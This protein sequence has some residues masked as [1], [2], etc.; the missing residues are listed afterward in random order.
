MEAE[1]IRYRGVLDME[2]ERG[3]GRRTYSLDSGP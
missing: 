1:G 2:D 3:G